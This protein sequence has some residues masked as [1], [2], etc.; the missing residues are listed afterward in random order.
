MLVTEP[1]KLNPVHMASVEKTGSIVPE[2][3]ETAAEVIDTPMK[4]AVG[5]EANDVRFKPLKS[6]EEKAL[7]RKMDILL[8]P[9]LSGSIL[10]AYL[11]GKT[12]VNTKFKTAILT[13]DIRIVAIS[14]ML[15]SWAYRRTSISTIN[16]TSTVL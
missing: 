7:V 10:F 4:E 8:L 15:V 11:V 12:P 3:H 2:H 1:P 5:I 13:R 9:L 6:P 14:A 16:S